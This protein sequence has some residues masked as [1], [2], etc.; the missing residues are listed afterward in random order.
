M[1]QGKTPA[2]TQYMQRCAVFQNES[3]VVLAASCIT[4]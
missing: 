3:L 2:L 4:K 1:Q